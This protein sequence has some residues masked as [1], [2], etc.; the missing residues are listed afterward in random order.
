METDELT[1]EQFLDLDSVGKFTVDKHS[2]GGV[3]KSFTY[4]RAFNIATV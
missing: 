3:A 1:L 2:T 4:S